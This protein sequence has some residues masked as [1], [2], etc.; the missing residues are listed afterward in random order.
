MV[1]QVVRDETSRGGVEVDRE[2]MC[3]HMALRRLIAKDRGT[4]ELQ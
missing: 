1:C 3:C 4:Q 2:R